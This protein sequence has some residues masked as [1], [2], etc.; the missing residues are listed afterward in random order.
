[1]GRF[2]ISEKRR[3]VMAAAQCKRMMWIR[4]LLLLSLLG[5]CSANPL[6]PPNSIRVTF[7]RSAQVIQL[8]VSNAQ[9]PRGARL[10]DAD[11]T[12]YPLPL[13]L[14]SGPHVNYSEPPTVGL[15]LGGFG[16]NVGGGAG[17]A[18][19]LGSP[20]P[21]GV[22]D[23]FIASARVAAPTDYAQHWSQYHLVV[24]VGPQ[25]LEIAAPA[26]A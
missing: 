6:P 25:T 21:V 5:S 17:V 2:L 18:F 7:E 9:M 1:M 26:P 20:H 19:P 13:T 3:R 10:V 11:G 22:D 24:D 14:V 12:Q 8:Y 16:W 23:Q 4:P 15:G